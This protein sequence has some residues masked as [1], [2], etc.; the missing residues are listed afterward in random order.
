MK[1]SWRNLD[2]RALPCRFLQS[3]IHVPVI[4]KIK[5]TNIVA[6]IPRR[7]PYSLKLLPNTETEG[8]VF[9]SLR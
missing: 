4:L 3:I 9:G 8:G 6:T 2:S 1:H 7:Y 5:D